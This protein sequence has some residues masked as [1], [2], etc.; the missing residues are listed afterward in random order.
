MFC[1]RYVLVHTHG[2]SIAVGAAAA[3]RP[4]SANQQKQQ[5]K[6]HTPQTIYRIE[7]KPRSSSDLSK[8]VELISYSNL[9]KIN[10]PDILSEATPGGGMV[11]FPVEGGAGGD[12]SKMMIGPKLYEASYLAKDAIGK[13]NFGPYW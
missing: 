12:R 3:L 10:G 6:Q 8:G 5:L 2:R 13:S 9:N 11:I 7:Y 4:C 1:S